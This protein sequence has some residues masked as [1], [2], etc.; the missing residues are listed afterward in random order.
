MTGDI[1]SQLVGTWRLVSYWAAGPGGDITQPMGPTPRGRLNYDASGRIFVQLTD[2]DRRAFMRANPRAGTNEEVRAAFASYIAD[3]GSYTVDPDRGTVTHHLEA[4][5]VPN[6]TGGDQVRHF[7][8]EGDRLT[9]KTPPNDAWRWRHCGN[10]ALGE[11]DLRSG[12]AGRSHVTERRRPTRACPGG[13]RYA[14]PI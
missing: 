13:V 10:L 12:Y 2:P 14:R 3:Y 5:L 1:H 6:W 7:L 9:L 8:L 4:S 11:A